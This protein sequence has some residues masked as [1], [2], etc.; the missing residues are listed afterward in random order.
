MMNKSTFNVNSFGRGFFVGERG[1]WR[2]GTVY[3]TISEILHAL[4]ELFQAIAKV[5]STLASK[6][7]S[8][9]CRRRLFVASTVLVTKSRHRLLVD[10][11]LRRQCQRAIK[12]LFN[13]NFTTSILL[14]ICCTASFVTRCATKP[15]QNDKMKVYNTS[16]T[17][18]E[19]YSLFSYNL[20]YNKSTKHWSNGVRLLCISVFRA[21]EMLHDISPYKIIYYWSELTQTC[22]VIMIIMITIFLTFREYQSVFKKLLL[23]SAHWVTDAKLTVLY[24]HW[25]W[26]ITRPKCKR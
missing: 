26:Q 23:L 20:L 19:F 15:Q 25:Q 14:L 3:W 4:A 13:P 12:T 18:R 11:R 10:F 9:F 7:K 5:P 22:V 17:S 2:A 6:S 16:T 1:V 21:V 8:I 24:K